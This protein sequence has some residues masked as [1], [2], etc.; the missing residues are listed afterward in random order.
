MRAVE[1]KQGLDSAGIERALEQLHA[2][3]KARGLKSSATRE[4]VARAALRRRGHFSVDQ[5]V[6]DLEQSE[7]PVVHPATVYRVLPLLVDAGLLQVTLIS[8][9]QGTLY[10]RAFEREHHDHLIC[11]ACGKVIEF[12]F[13]AIEV[14]Q[15]D[16]A[17]RFGF[18]LTGHVHELLGTCTACRD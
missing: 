15:R 7:A 2:L 5:L 6:A 1:T 4:A 13:E 8:Q 14:L 10:E 11:T 17:E 18:R 3:V 9:G 16:V 12:E